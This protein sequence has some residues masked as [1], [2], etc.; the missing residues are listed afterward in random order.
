MTGNKTIR[1]LQSGEI[2]VAELRG[3]SDA[4]MKAGIEAG[5]KLMDAGEHQAAAEVLAGLALY[6]PYRPDVW[7]A[8]EELFRRERQPGPAN[9]FSS[10]SR[11]MAA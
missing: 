4:E 7:S 5:R 11:A 3:I 1:A 8:L 6:D 9:L 10:L 2:T